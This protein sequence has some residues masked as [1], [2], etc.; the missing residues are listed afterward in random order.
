MVEVT[1]SRGW[2]VPVMGLFVATFA[3]C[4]AELIVTGLLP[5]IASDLRVDIPTAGLLISGYALGVAIAGPLLALL[6]AKLERRTVMLA[7]IG[8]FI[9]GNVICGVSGSYGMLL[10]GRLL[11]AACHGLFFGVAMVIAARLAPEGRQASAISLVVAG[12]TLANI[13][14]VPIG[15]AIGAA[16]GWRSSFWV[17]A[18][19]GALAAV[20]LFIVIPRTPDPARGKDDFRAELAA[21]KRPAVLICYS[22]IAIVMVGVIALQGY[23]V[24]L[25]T[26]RSGVPAA[27]V[28]WVLLGMGATGFVGNLAGGRLGDWKPNATMS[29][30]LVIF[31]VLL[32]VMWQLTGSA[33]GMVITLW[34]T[35]GVGFGF[36]A[37]VQSRILHEARDA[38]NLASTLIST[39]FNIGIAAGAAVGGGAISAGWGYGALPLITAAFTA[40]AFVGTLLLTAYDRRRRPAPAAS[41][42]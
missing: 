35:W 36:P 38:P 6:T 19:A 5:N 33:W 7:V 26:E 2:I 22:F 20:V 27:Y 23:I 29:G 18:A 40:L 1:A 24:P 10:A 39:A 14:G 21:A 4:T 12:V 42:A 9:L 32:L 28:P 15:T 16:Y 37:P 8:F 31:F 11:V 41:P 13:L 30:I 25:L 17:I 3:V 34:A